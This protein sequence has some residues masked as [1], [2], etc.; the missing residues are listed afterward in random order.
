[1]TQVC[2]LQ[3]VAQPRHLRLVL[4]RR[5][6][7][8]ICGLLLGDQKQLTRRL[9][10]P[11]LYR[12]CCCKLRYVFGLLLDKLLRLVSQLRLSLRCCLLRACCC[13]L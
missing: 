7:Q 9:T 1:M 3:D 5:T 8:C 6:R 13:G 11:L 10:V 12:V 2:L 4:H